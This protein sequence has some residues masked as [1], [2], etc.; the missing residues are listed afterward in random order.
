MISCDSFVSQK[1]CRNLTM[2][3]YSMC[4]RPTWS[5]Q[6][7]SFVFIL[8]STIWYTQQLLVYCLL[9]NRIVSKTLSLHKSGPGLVAFPTICRN[10]SLADRWQQ[11]PNIWQCQNP[12]CAFFNLH[13]NILLKL[14]QSH[15]KYAITPKT[16][17]INI[18]KKFE[19][20]YI[21][22]FDIIIWMAQNALHQWK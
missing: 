10:V 13:Q 14:K 2:D 11:F 9:A 17:I 15:R 16:F 1:P 8:A 7:V 21:T 4:N 5:S 18:V 19:T 20:I 12:L 3:F 6:T 22:G